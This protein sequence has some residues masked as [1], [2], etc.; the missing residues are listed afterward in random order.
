MLQLHFRPLHILNPL[1]YYDPNG[2]E[3]EEPSEMADGVP[4]GGG[5]GGFGGGGGSGR[6][7]GGG[8]DSPSKS[9]T[10][11]ENGSKSVEK[12][13]EKVVTPTTNN[14]TNDAALLNQEQA[15][16][17]RIQ[18]LENSKQLQSNGAFRKGVELPSDATIVRGGVS[19]AK[20]LKDNQADDPNLTISANGGMGV[21]NGTLAGNVK[22]NQITVTTVKQLNEIGY[23]VISSPSSGNVYHVDIVPPNK[24]KLTDDEA[25][26]LSSI[27]KAIPKPKN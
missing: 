4:G 1:K 16:A 27:F 5:G 24:Q 20:N 15:S 13:A 9:I 11:A 3:E 19:A 17:R 7:P 14:V 21:S 23:K 10:N 25:K 18:Q 6:P 12:S 26:K 8:S 22:N 2:H